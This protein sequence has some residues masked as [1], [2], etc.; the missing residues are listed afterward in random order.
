MTYVSGY[1]ANTGPA[2]PLQDGSG[3]LSQLANSIGGKRKFAARCTKVCIAGRSVNSPHVR[4]CRLWEG[5]IC[6]L[7]MPSMARPFVSRQSREN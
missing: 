3:I 5:C 1:T 2:D 6:S 7:T 4:Q